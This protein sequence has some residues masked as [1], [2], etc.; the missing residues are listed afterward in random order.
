MPSTEDSKKNTVSS[1]E[2]NKKWT[3][4]KKTKQNKQTNNSG[5]SAEVF[6]FNLY[7]KH[8]NQTQI[9]FT[10]QIDTVYNS[11]TKSSI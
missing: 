2:Y 11:A 3:D 4:S 8:N 5:F 6:L 10:V 9:Q 1:T 7:I